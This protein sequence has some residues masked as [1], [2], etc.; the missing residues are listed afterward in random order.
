MYFYCTDLY[1]SVRI[2]DAHCKHLYG[3]EAPSLIIRR[4]YFSRWMAWMTKTAV[5]TGEKVSSGSIKTPSSEY[6]FGA[7]LFAK[8]MG[9]TVVDRPADLASDV[10]E[11]R[12]RFSLNSRSEGGGSTCRCTDSEADG[13]E[14]ITQLA[15]LR[16]RSP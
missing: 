1:R 4:P 5:P 15:G 14:P 12:F 11:K 2:L 7:S 6:K 3:S 16:G 13:D 8:D 10:W 9:A